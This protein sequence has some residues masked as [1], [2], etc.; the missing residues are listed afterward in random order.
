MSRFAGEEGREA[1]SA[2]F[3]EV[4]NRIL[5]PVGISFRWSHV[6]IHIHD[7]RIHMNVQ[8]LEGGKVFEFPCVLLL[9]GLGN[10][11]RTGLS[12]FWVLP[13]QGIGKS[14]RQKR[15]DPSVARIPIPD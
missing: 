12:L 11:R 6:E 14:L 15:L 7:G 4:L 8:P 9:V 5:V 1:V 3:T 13:G 10:F 2:F